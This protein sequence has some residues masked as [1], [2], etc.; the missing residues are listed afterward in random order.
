MNVGSVSPGDNISITEYHSPPGQGSL[1]QMMR[2]ISQDL[3][4]FETGGGHLRVLCRRP[5]TRV[6][7]TFLIAALKRNSRYLKLTRR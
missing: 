2:K 4:L 7:V 3:H 5:D 6:C 1:N